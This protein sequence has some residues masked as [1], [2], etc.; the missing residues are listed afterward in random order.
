VAARRSNKIA[1]QYPPD[2]LPHLDS[3]YRVATA[4]D[5]NA[6]RGM[7]IHNL[8]CSEVARWPRDGAETL[9]SLRAAVPM[10]ERLCSNP[11]RMVRAEFL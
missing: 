6:G 4:A 8:H 2:R 3:E 11:R 7:T 10:V 5:P 9:A 1:R